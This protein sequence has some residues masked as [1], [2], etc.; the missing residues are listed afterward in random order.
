MIARDFARVRMIALCVFALGMLAAPASAVA[1]GQHNAGAHAAKAKG[2]KK[3]P[4]KKSTTIVLVKCAS[5]TVTCKGTPGAA[6]P[7]GAPGVNGANGSSIVLRA[8]SAGSTTVGKIAAPPGCDSFVTCFVGQSVPVSPSTWTEGP[9]EDDQLIGGPVTVALPSDAA[10]GA[11]EN[12]TKKEPETPEADVLVSVD[13]LL[14]GVTEAKGGTA[15]VTKNVAL[16]LNLSFFEI[17]GEGSSEYGSG[18]F[19]GNGA[20]Q[21]HTLVVS[22]FDN[23][24]DAHAAIS[25]VAIDVLASF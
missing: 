25:N 1:A 2:K 19:V 4:K 3:K 17:E 22:A 13:G 9:T 12:A 24:N 20:S 5:V 11:E 23:C 15:A 8:R 6:G 7:Q 21:S 14:E 18:A 16:G 10:C